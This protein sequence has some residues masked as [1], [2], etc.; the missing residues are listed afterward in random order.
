MDAPKQSEQPR[1]FSKLTEKETRELRTWILINR[2]QQEQKK[3]GQT[4]DSWIKLPA[5][6]KL[7]GK[8]LTGWDF[9]GLYLN[10]SSF[11][12]CL[13]TSAC[14][15]G[16]TMR[17][18]SFRGATLCSTTS[19]TG[20]SLTSVHFDDA[21]L[22][23][24]NLSKV[25]TFDEITFIWAKLREVRFPEISSSKPQ[26]DFSGADLSKLDLS[27]ISDLSAG[28]F[29]GATFNEVYFIGTNLTHGSFESTKITQCSFDRASL[30]R[31]NWDGTEITHTTFE[32]AD[33]S[34]ARFG[35][36]KARC[37]LTD[38]RFLGAKLIGTDLSNTTIKGC[39]FEDNEIASTA[40]R[41][42]DKLRPFFHPGVEF[43]SDFT[44]I[45]PSREEK[46]SSREDLEDLPS[47]PVSEHTIERHAGP[48]PS[49]AQQP[50][51][52]PTPDSSLEKLAW[53]ALVLTGIAAAILIGAT[54]FGIGPLAFLLAT[55]LIKLIAVGVAT[56]CL[57][58]LAVSMVNF[59]SSS[60]SKA[61]DTSE[62]SSASLLHHP[63]ISPAHPPE[64]REAKYEEVP[65]VEAA[66]A[67][68]EQVLEQAFT[69]YERGS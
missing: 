24:V 66:A 33:L 12:R 60:P 44:R 11:D 1:Q 62:S 6:P 7:I 65:Q 68:Q 51:L 46:S 16:T 30:N 18:V 59:I 41:D 69:T 64:R 15:D 37:K 61:A 39:T 8:N 32:H 40:T 28:V 38:V 20:A 5:F 35:S 17:G 52:K 13:L 10:N 49:I 67:S 3:A 21:E 55:P 57:A 25:S 36:P 2:E 54:T 63:I 4:E 58:P 23:R 50:A 14:F 31:T 48:E 42:F 22:Y 9:S 26:L 27:A 43:N 34:H 53:V 47:K 56:L 45:Q 29:K 19:F